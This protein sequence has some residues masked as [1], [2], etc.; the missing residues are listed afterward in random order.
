[1][2]P[3]QSIPLPTAHIIALAPVSPPA[4]AQRANPPAR[5]A[6]PRSNN[7]ASG[8]GQR[9]TTPNTTAKSAR[10]AQSNTAM[11]L[12][13]IESVPAKTAEFLP[14]QRTMSPSRTPSPPRWHTPAA[15]LCR[16]APSRMPSHRWRQGR[17]FSAPAATQP[18]ARFIQKCP[19]PK[20]HTP[21][22]PA[23]A[24][25]AARYDHRVRGAAPADAAAIPKCLL[26]HI[27][28]SIKS[29]TRRRAADSTSSTARRANAV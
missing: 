22:S 11:P 10:P 20:C 3:R 28:V 18:A 24:V 27:V 8:G 29:Y 15:T 25:A 1:M 9:H 5:A 17:V 13:T 6:R 23:D 2:P 16:R 26:K 12:P 21:H 14:T 7:S 4:T 19:P